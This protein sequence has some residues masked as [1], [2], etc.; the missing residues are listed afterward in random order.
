L[1]VIARPVKDRPQMD[2]AEAPKPAVDRISAVPTVPV[3][4]RV[5]ARPVMG[6]TPTSPV[7]VPPTTPPPPAAPQDQTS[8]S[9][10][11][12]NT[13]YSGLQTTLGLSDNALN[14]GWTCVGVTGAD[15]YQARVLRDR[16]AHVLA[17]AQS[18]STF[19]ITKVDLEVA[20]KVL[21]CSNQATG[22]KP[23]QNAYIALGV[24]VV[25]AAIFLSLT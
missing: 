8:I 3:V 2:G 9:L 18:S 25:G 15:F 10:S 4:E 24:I 19:M 17:S 13:I 14:T 20:G 7:A 21:D 5:Q 6:Q 12:A 16:L 23:N 22:A 1:T 11:E